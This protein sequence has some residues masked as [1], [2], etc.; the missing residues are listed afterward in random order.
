MPGLTQANLARLVGNDP[1]A[2]ALASVV[3]SLPPSEPSPTPD[4]EEM[5]KVANTKVKA[6]RR[7]ARKGKQK[8]TAMMGPMF[9]KTTWGEKFEMPYGQCAAS[10]SAHSS[11]WE[12]DWIFREPTPTKKIICMGREPS[13]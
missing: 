3:S 9:R 8:E 7:T 12:P 10:V 5:A 6:Q 11:E 1:V 2:A 4:F 13:L